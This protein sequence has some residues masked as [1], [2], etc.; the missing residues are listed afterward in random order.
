M[1]DFL[2]GGNLYQLLEDGF[3]VAGDRV[4]FR[5]PSGRVLMSYGD[6]RR[7]VCRFANALLSR[8]I[9]PGDRISVQIDKSLGTVV[10]YLASLKTGA[11]FH[12]LNP[13]YTPHEVDYFLEDAEPRLIVSSQA[14]AAGLGASARHRG[15]GFETLDEFSGSLATLAASLPDRHAT[16]HRSGDDLACLLYTSGTTGRSK[17]VMITHQNLSTNALALRA[18]WAFEPGDVLIHALP[19]FHVHGLHVALHT[20]FLN[21]SEII[22]LPRFEV[23]DL[24]RSLR[25]ATVLMGVPTFYARLLG[26]PDFGRAVCAGMRLFIS[27]S[28]PLAGEVHAAFLKRTGYAILER[29]GMTEAGMIASNPYAG[30]RLAGSVGFPLPGV[31]V[32]I[33]DDKGREVARGE[34][35][36]IE[37]RGPNVFKGYWRVPASN[38]HDFRNDGFF[39]TGDLGSMAAD[40]RISI[41]GRARDLIIS[42]GL[43]VYPKEVEEA[44]D[45]LPGIVESAVFGVPHPDLGEAVI[46]VAVAERSAPERE[47]IATLGR[48]LA[49]FKLPKRIFLIGNL[50]RNAM[51]KVQKADLRRR[52]AGTFD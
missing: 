16:C 26:E 1:A 7:V 19:V 2:S 39:I 13:A 28:A 48:N 31:T 40:G 27:G 50:P 36:M 37:V 12:P 20:S 23:G 21:G 51:G 43:N 9:E 15:I 4:A 5:S 42:G 11:V 30:E 24:L 17:G 45:R 38:N 44:L 25:S 22:W 14:H 18:L 47:M 8:G 49:R 52:Y 46:A 6:L 41:V 34:T 33:A 3:Q 10:L 35:G 32:R 29:Y